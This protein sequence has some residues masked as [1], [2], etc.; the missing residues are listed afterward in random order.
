MTQWRN[1]YG[2]PLPK[3]A[4]MIGLRIQPIWLSN[5]DSLRA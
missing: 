2:E 1:Q 5:F 3:H 4:P